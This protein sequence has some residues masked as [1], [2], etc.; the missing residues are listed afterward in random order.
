MNKNM[1][2]NEVCHWELE[3]NKL[4]A[5]KVTPF[6]LHAILI[7]ESMIEHLSLIRLSSPGVEDVHDRQKP[8][9]YL[10]SVD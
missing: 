1:I 9:K 10:A 5:S 6:R 2:S 3:Q 8:K 4:F 7:I